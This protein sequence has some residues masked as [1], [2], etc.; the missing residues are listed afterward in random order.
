M[1]GFDSK[2]PTSFLTY[3]GGGGGSS[4]GSSDGTT[5]RGSRSIT[6]VSVFVAIIDYSL[7]IQGKPHTYTYSVFVASQH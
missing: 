7:L 5:V 6:S 2:P 1:C 3:D 4:V